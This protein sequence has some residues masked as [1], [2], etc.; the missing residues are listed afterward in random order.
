MICFS[1]CIFIYPQEN[2]IAKRK[3]FEAFGSCIETFKEFC[4]I[5]D[6]CSRDYGCMVVKLS[7]SSSK[8]TD[9]IFWYKAKEPPHFRVGSNK[10]WNYHKSN[11]DET[12][13]DKQQQHEKKLQ[14]YVNKQ[15]DIVDYNQV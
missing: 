3:V 1:Q 12:F 9:K 8:I 2:P 5:L 11:Y 10:Y 14:I 13:I 6:Q 15:G 4:D 7:G